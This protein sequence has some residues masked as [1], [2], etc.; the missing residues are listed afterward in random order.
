M[1]VV[2][3]VGPTS[4]GMPVP[5]VLR[6]RFDAAFMIALI[7][8]LE[9]ALATANFLGSALV[10]HLLVLKTSSAVFAWP[11]YVLFGLGLGLVYAI[12]SAN[13]VFR[14]FDGDRKRYAM[15]PSAVIDWT[16]AFAG[17]LL[18]AFLVG[19]VGS[20]S[21]VSLTTTYLIGLT[22]GVSGRGYLQ[23]VLLARINRGDLR[24]QKIAVVGAHLEVLEF[25]LTGDLWRH[26]QEIVGTLYLEDLPEDGSEKAKA[27]DRFAQTVT[28]RGASYVVI[29]SDIAQL[30][31]TAPFLGELKRFSLNV[32][33]AL[34]ENREGVNFVDVVPIGPA[35]TLRVLK[36]PLSGLSVFF[37]RAMDISAASLGLV[38]LTPFFAMAALLIKLESPGPVL[39][40][41]DRRGFNGEAFSI[42]KFR[43]MRVMESGTAMRQATR[44]DTRVTRIGKVLRATSF[45]ELPQ[46]INVLR[47]E[48]SLV[49]P[50]P[51]ALSH[52]TEMGQQLAEYAHRRRVKPGITGWAQVNGYRGETRTL[53]QIEGRTR[54]DLHYIDNWSVLFDVWIILLTLF[55]PATRRNAY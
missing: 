54:Y 22:L 9:G 2:D 19:Q 18:F 10:Y 21:R 33:Y 3:E 13:S 42:L 16:M 26:G 12:L 29:A 49:G 23:G 17:V 8:V 31:D 46:L 45:D 38:L 39:F 50:R 48:M 41:Q 35:N 14:F 40:R 47:G 15:L 43:S 4:I 52:D 25:L 37:K 28:S 55:S 6:R 1:T 36:Q 5:V 27:I 44:D 11:L 24:Y 7:A 20:L 32:V 34:T 30:R 51:H 53:D